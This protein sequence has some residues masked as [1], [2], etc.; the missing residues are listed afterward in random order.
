M[1]E[2]KELIELRG[3]AIEMANV[4]IN[5]S[6]KRAYNDLAHALNVL[7]AMVARC[8]VEEK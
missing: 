8:T 6:W 5:P 2:R 4:V 7:D 3:R 1:F